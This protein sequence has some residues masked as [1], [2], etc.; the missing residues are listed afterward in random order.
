MEENRR[1]K[2]IKLSLYI[3][4]ID[5]TRNNIEYRNSIK[6]LGALSTALGEEEHKEFMTLLQFTIGRCLLK[7][8][9]KELIATCKKYFS[10]KKAAALLG[11]S[12]TG[13]NKK[14]GDLLNRNFD[15]EEYLK[16]LKPIIETEHGIT[17][18]NFL[19]KFIEDFKFEIGNDD[20]D[21]YDNNR[22][23]ELEFLLIYNKLIEVFNSVG[24]IDKFIFYLCNL[25]DIDYTSIAQLKNNIH[26]INRSYPNFRYNTRYLMQE[27]VT[28]YTHKGLT[29]GTIGSKVLGKTSSYLYNGT[30][31]KYT[32]ISDENMNWQYTPTI[33]WSNINKGS[34][35]KFID[36]FHTFIKY[37]S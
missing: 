28:L 37:G 3:N 9:E 32:A 24:L 22:T 2:E 15:N 16:T 27:I 29:K 8:T 13:Y 4:Y 35:M 18:I 5:R 11:L 20:H 17:M 33:D 21:L 30:N 34:V 1:L 10:H 31:K 12:H 7:A 6:M 14:Y 25:C 19:T 26:I 23:L 36:L